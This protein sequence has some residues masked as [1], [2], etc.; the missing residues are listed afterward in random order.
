MRPPTLCLALLLL[1]AGC[2][3]GTEVVSPRATQPREVSPGY[4]ISDTRTGS[5]GLASATFYPD[6]V[7]F[8]VRKTAAN[9]D[10]G[11]WV[12]VDADANAGTGY[13]QGATLGIEFVL[14]SWDASQG[15]ANL[16]FTNLDYGWSFDGAP[17]AVLRMYTVG[18][19]WVV[20]IP[21]SYFAGSRNAR[22]F[23]P[24]I[25]FGSKEAHANEEVAGI[26]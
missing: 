10:V 17:D 20:N 19:S 11:M 26:P 5:S 15:Y 4:A 1:T 13:A 24:Y 7:R 14:G 2:R 8:T 22:V 3:M 12:E 25:I 9:A 6:Y 16:R 21:R 23:T 18:G